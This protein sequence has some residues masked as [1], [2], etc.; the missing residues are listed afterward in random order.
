MRAS[1]PAHFPDVVRR[2]LDD[3][4]RMSWCIHRRTTEIAF[5][6]ALNYYCLY[7]PADYINTVSIPPCTTR[8]IL[9]CSWLLVV[10][11]LFIVVGMWLQNL[12]PG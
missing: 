5:H 3:V 8:V 1:C 10:L 4:G 6:F 12:F 9:G 11:E 2:L 7:F